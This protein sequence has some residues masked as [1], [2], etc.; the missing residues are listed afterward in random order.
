MIITR[1]DISSLIG[2]DHTRHVEDFR[3]PVIFPT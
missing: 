2:F 3:L 1:S